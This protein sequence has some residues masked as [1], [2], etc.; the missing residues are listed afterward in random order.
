MRGSPAA[1]LAGFGGGLLY[2]TLMEQST[3]EASVS[4]PLIADAFKYPDD[5]SSATYRLDPRAQMA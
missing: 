4:H 3:D 5:Y 1:G 2:D